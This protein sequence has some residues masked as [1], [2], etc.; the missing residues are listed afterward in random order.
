M[1]RVSSR[2]ATVAG[3]V[4]GAA[5]MAGAIASYFIS[6]WQLQHA[7]QAPITGTGEI[8]PYFI[9]GATIYLDSVDLAVETWLLPS[10]IVLGLLAGSLLA[11]VKRNRTS[12]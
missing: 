1:N 8:H 5:A 10:M 12:L 9:R 6:T 2:M 7:P 4:L 11:W 3:W